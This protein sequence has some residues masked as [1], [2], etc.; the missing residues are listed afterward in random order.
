MTCTQKENCQTLFRNN[1]AIRTNY[2]VP[3]L[4]SRSKR[5]EYSM[6]DMYKK[7]LLKVQELVWS[8]F[9]LLLSCF[10][11]N[12]DYFCKRT[13]TIRRTKQNSITITIQRRK[14]YGLSVEVLKIRNMQEKLANIQ[15]GIYHLI[16]FKQRKGSKVFWNKVLRTMSTRTNVARRYYCI[17]QGFL[18]DTAYIRCN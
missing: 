3:C 16:K 11:V 5:C 1:A 18:S 15:E 8:T 17:I 12:D 6:K 2:N 9:S 7:L 14:H 10:A 13:P 4:F